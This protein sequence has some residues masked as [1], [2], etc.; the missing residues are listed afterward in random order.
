VLRRGLRSFA[1]EQPSAA[2][3][4]LGF[5]NDMR[6]ADWPAD[7]GRN[8]DK[9]LDDAYLDTHDDRRKRRATGKKRG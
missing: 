7:V 8:H 2:A 6:G 5:M 9:Y 1:R 4:L 3:P